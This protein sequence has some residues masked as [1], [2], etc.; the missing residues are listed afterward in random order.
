MK[1]MKLCT[2][3]EIFFKKAL[4][5]LI[6][7]HILDKIARIRYNIIIFNRTGDEN[8]MDVA[9]DGSDNDNCGNYSVTYIYKRHG[10]HY[11]L[12]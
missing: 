8:L 11:R 4:S 1:R 3:T 6:I 5:L 12:C 9:P 10:L 7:Y 2:E